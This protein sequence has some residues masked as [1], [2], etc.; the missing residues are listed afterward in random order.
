MDK[1]LRELNKQF[2]KHVLTD[3][4]GLVKALIPTPANCADTVVLP[5]L[6]EKSELARGGECACR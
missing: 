6:L 4:Q 1:L 3:E 2:K 5:D